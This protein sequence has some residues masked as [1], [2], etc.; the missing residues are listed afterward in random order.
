MG[1]EVLYKSQVTLSDQMSAAIAGA[2]KFID[3]GPKKRTDLAFLNGTDMPAILL[4]VCFVDSEADAKLYKENF[5]KICEAI[6]AT[7]HHVEGEAKPP[8]PKSLI[9]SAG[10]PFW[11][12]E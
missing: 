12:T 10:L 8:P 4:E 11:R 2:G 6:A 9:L 1:C 7:L 3:R 5:E